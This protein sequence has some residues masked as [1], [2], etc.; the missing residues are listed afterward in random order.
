M[1]CSYT[2]PCIFAYRCAHRSSRCNDWGNLSIRLRSNLRSYGDR[3]SSLARR[4]REIQS[5]SNQNPELNQSES[6]HDLL[7][8]TI[9]RPSM[10]VPSNEEIVENDSKPALQFE[11]RFE[12]RPLNWKDFL[13]EFVE[14]E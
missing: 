2:V 9:A 10:T 5:S 7:G 6:D 3:Q 11:V 12:E 4:G 8:V 13:M 14:F 1:T